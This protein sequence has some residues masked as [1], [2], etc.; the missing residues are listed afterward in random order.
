MCYTLRFSLS[1]KRSKILM[2]S[3]LEVLESDALRLGLESSVTELRQLRRLLLDFLIKKPLTQLDH[4]KCVRGS[5][6][7][8]GNLESSNLDSNACSQA[9]C[10]LQSANFEPTPTS[11][12]RTNLCAP[13]AHFNQCADCR[14]SGCSGELP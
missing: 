10:N 1:L 11:A 6:C 12:I 8:R 9:D 14:L 3:K 4:R 7:H 5:S 2:A 13:I